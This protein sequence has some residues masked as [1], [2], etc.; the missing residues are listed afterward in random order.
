MHTKVFCDQIR[1]LRYSKNWTV[2]PEQW[3]IDHCLSQ[4]IP[5]EGCKLE[6]SVLILAAIIGCDLVKI[7]VVVLMLIVLKE[8]PCV[9]LGD[10]IAHFLRYPDTSTGDRCLMDQKRTLCDSMNFLIHNED[11][12]PFWAQAMPAQPVK[13]TPSRKRWYHS[14][15]PERWSW[16]ILV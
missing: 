4:R 12:S 13:W 15:S 5:D 8:T 14:P 6:Y 11:A 7:I 10:A 2:A 1:A 9:T 3:P 16:V